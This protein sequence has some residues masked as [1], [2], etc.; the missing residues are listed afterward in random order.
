[1]LGAA[2]SIAAVRVPLTQIPNALPAAASGPRSTAPRGDVEAEDAA[3]RG[4]LGPERLA[5]G[6]E[7]DPEPRVGARPVVGGDDVAVAVDALDRRRLRDD[8]AAAA[9]ARRQQLDVG[10]AVRAAEV[11]EVGEVGAGRDVEA[12]HDRRRRVGA[13][14]VEDR[15]LVGREVDQGRG[16]GRGELLDRRPGAAELAQ[17]LRVGLVADVE[18]AVAIEGD[19][20]RQRAGRDR[21][22]ELVVGRRPE[23]AH[24]LCGAEGGRIEH[25]AAVEGTADRLGATGTPPDRST[26]AGSRRCRRRCTCRG[27][28]RRRRR[29]S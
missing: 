1:M 2:L 9:V 14:R 29:R 12:M 20:L 16:A 10:D 3:R 25:A 22:T 28:C 27:W 11:R 26:R 18:V 7:R 13:V 8:R 23:E 4:G 21:G 24:E 5:V 15:A 17:R 19:G 6:I